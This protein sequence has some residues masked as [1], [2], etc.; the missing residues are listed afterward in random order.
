M[1]LSIEF[2]EELSRKEI[3]RRKRIARM[4][5][6]YR[7]GGTLEEVGFEWGITRQRVEQIF[8]PL[9]VLGRGGRPIKTLLAAPQKREKKARQIQTSEASCLSRYGMSREALA[10]ISPLRLSH[11][12]H[13]VSLFG[14]LRSR[15]KKEGV[16][17]D[18]K[19]VDWWRAWQ[20]S[21][22]WHERGRQ[23]YQMTRW[24]RNQGWSRDNI[25]IVT[26]SERFSDGFIQ[27]SA[28]A[29][30][31]TAKKNREARS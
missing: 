14:D 10:A 17:F 25:R 1:T 19:F 2:I 20:E 26:V 4:L 12:R 30:R 11:V 9:G 31:E 28:K 21:G 22:H 27:C 29:R 13:P 6:V 7:G 5:E 24:D 16:K 15:I 3:W 8:R 23:G 18:L